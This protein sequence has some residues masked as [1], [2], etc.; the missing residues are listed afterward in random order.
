MLSAYLTIFF[1][2]FVFICFVIVGIRCDKIIPPIYKRLSQNVI[3]SKIFLSPPK[4]AIKKRKQIRFDRST[5][6]TGSLLFIFGLMIVIEPKWYSIKFEYYIDLSDLK[7]P[8]GLLLMGAGSFLFYHAFSSKNI[9]YYIC[10]QC[11]KTISANDVSMKICKNC[12]A[13]LVELKGFYERY[14]EL[15][16]KA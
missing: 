1:I 14:P 15:R 13:T 7:W 11:R 9:P 12:G 16:E 10:P 4:N 5:F 8:I 3:F 6:D 2:I